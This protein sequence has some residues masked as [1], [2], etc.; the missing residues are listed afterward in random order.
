M[1]TTSA[2]LAWQVRLDHGTAISLS[3]NGRN[4]L[5]GTA[6]ARKLLAYSITP[7][8]K[9]TKAGLALR[10]EY[11]PS[12]GAHKGVRSRALK[13]KP[14]HVLSSTRTRLPRVLQAILGAILAP[15]GKSI[16][17][18]GDDL[19]VKLWSM[20]GELIAT[21]SNK[22]GEQCAPL[23]TVLGRLACPHLLTALGRSACV[24]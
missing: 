10:R 20:A 13:P 15:N 17:T 18:L 8:G 16:V 12:G 23:L 3:P 19:N 2:R 5:V 6:S 4:V 14:A 22:V 21:V 11:A 9:S 1:M 24:P 7:P